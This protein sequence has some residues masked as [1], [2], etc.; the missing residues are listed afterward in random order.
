MSIIYP[1]YIEGTLPAF[2]SSGLKIPYENNPAVIG[3]TSF[4]AK[5][6]DPINN[7]VIAENIMGTAENNVITFSAPSG[8]IGGNYYKIQV[9]YNGGR[10]YAFSSSGVARYLGNG[11][12]KANLSISNYVATGTYTDSTG[13]NEL[14]YSYE[15]KV[16]KNGQIIEST[17]SQTHTSD[18]DTFSLKYVDGEY[19]IKYIATSINGYKVEASANFSPS[20]SLGGD[21][22][23]I[24]L[25]KDTGSIS[26]DSLSW[27]YGNDLTLVNLNNITEDNTVKHGVTYYYGAVSGNTF[28]SVYNPVEAYFEHMFLS[29]AEKQLCIKFNPKVS[30]F[31]NTIMESK[32]DTIGGKYPIFFRNGNVDYKEFSISGLISYQMDEAEKFMVKEELGLTNNSIRKKTAADAD[33]TMEK[34]PSIALVDYN[35]YAERKFRE[36]VLVW[37]NNGKPKLFRSPTE[38]NYVVRLMNISLSPEDTLGRMLYSFNCSAYQVMD[39][40][41]DKMRAAGVIL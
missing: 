11:Q 32:V 36:E 1:P 17:G 2:T 14:E 15:F 37:L 20:I 19:Q 4:V 24:K 7:E 22:D 13:F 39:L 26:S 8:L 21:S 29:D 41:Y 25:N 27:R 30:T 34:V 23:K 18:L 31:K 5:I 38:G 16:L 33:S 40:D 35:I 28:S 6:T 3:T 12:I 9:A 10:P